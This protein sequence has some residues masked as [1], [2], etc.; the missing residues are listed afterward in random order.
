MPPLTTKPQSECKWD[1]VSLG[2]VMLRL[3]PYDARISTT[4]TFRVWEGGGEYNVA[5]GLLR[6]FGMRT[7]VVTA[8]TDNPVGRLV[9]DLIYQGGVDQSHV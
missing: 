8:L 2:E 3:D 1:L 9:Q 7:T 4:R 6:C 5:R